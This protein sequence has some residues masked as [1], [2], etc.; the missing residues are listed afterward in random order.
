MEI[1]INGRMVALGAISPETP[2]LYV[3]RNDLGLNGPK[4]GCG[5]GECGACTVLI[6]GVA[7]RSC[8]I[9]L[10]GVIDKSITTLEG[11]S[12]AGQ[13]HPVQQGFID[14]QAAQCGY[15][16]NGMI[17]TLVALF[18][19]NPQADE[20]EIKNELAYNL[21]RCGTHIEILRAAAKARQLLAE[22]G[23]A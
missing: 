13:L 23:Q 17:M 18:E 12:E 8:S 1:K 7:A 16:T 21:C 19:R 10:S 2:L 14:E 22:R 9:P 20:Q 3:L 5:L 11:L 15:C 4:Y 6:D